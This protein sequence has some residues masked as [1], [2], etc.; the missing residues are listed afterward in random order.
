MTYP[1][2]ATIDQSAYHLGEVAVSQLLGL[3]HYVTKKDNNQLTLTVK[4]RGSI[5]K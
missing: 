5:R 1:Q 3:S 2:I 4:R